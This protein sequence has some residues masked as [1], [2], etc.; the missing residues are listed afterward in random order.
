MGSASA[1]LPPTPSPARS[2]GALLFVVSDSILA[3]GEFGPPALRLPRT[4]L[5]VMVT[6]YAAQALLAW[7]AVRTPVEPP[8]RATKAAAATTAP[9]AAPAPESAGKAATGGRS[10]TGSTAT[11]RSIKAKPS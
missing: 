10:G 5:W 4:K 1:N 7:A 9:A 2:A 3:I 6:Y 11:R 8:P